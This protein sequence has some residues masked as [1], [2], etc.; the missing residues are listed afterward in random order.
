MRID[1]DLSS[2]LAI[3]E[4]AVKFRYSK[5]RRQHSSAMASTNQMMFMLR[6]AAPRLTRSLFMCHHAC[7]S[8]HTSQQS[9][10]LFGTSVRRLSSD[11]LIPGPQVASQI[12][13]TSRSLQ[14]SKRKASFFPEL[15]DKSVAYW[16]LGSAAS[17]FGIVV[18]GGL[19]RLT[20]S[21]YVNM[22]ESLGM[23]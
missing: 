18:F 22:L 16:L 14:S 2:S 21:G 11:G 9:K 17:V 5:P 1:R 20:E 4:P 13:N 8:P 7:K 15:S 12:A 10:R 19:T 23:C 6:K 3:L